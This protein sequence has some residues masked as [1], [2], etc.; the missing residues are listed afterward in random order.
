MDTQYFF[1]IYDVIAEGDPH[2]RDGRRG[3]RQPAVT[4]KA[5]INM[6]GA[7]IKNQRESS[8]PRNRDVKDEASKFLYIEKQMLA[9]GLHDSNAGDALP[10][11]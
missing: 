1:N 11:P 9:G 7:I 5:L 8:I 10:D 3:E 2:A 4:D 6:C